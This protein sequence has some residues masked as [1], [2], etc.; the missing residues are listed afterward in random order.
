MND[1][2]DHAIRLAA[3]SWLSEQTRIHGEVL[4]RS[5]LLNGFTFQGQRVPLVS[6]QGIFKP[7][8]AQ[9]PLTISTTTKGPYDDSFDLRGLLQY[10]YRGTNPNHPDNIGLRECMKQRIPLVY[11]HSVV[12]GKY[13]AVW[14]V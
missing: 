9:Y 6:P 7:A 1:A 14:P 12:P 5:L 13:L 3:V 11:L 8:V 4:S 2:S 10:S